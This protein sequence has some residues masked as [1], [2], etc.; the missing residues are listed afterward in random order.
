MKKD[1]KQGL[2]TSRRGL[3]WGVAAGASLLLTGCPVLFV[4]GV[5]TGAAVAL[6][7]RTGGAQADDQIINLHVYQDVGKVL[8][9]GHI[10]VNS[11]NR[12]VL[13]TGEVRNAEQKAQVEAIA[14]QVTNVREVINALAIGP[15]TGLGSRSNDT[16]LTGK[17]KAALTATEG[18][19]AA[20]IK[21]VTER[22]V[23]YLMGLLTESEAAIAAGAAATVGGVRQVVRVFEILTEAEL[24]KILDRVDETSIPTEENTLG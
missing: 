24:K 23:V 13:L 6:D 11:Y 1:E 22:S 8:T 14:R 15:N 7:R 5:A 16:Y 3:L 18:V 10:N 19:S 20:D 4:G 2:K 21:V 9:D 17:V 12:R